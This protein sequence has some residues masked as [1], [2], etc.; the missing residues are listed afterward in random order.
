VQPTC[1]ILCAEPR[2]SQARLTR[3]HHLTARKRPS[4]QGLRQHT[5]LPARLSTTIALRDQGQNRGSSVASL[6]STSPCRVECEFSFTSSR[7]HRPPARQLKRSASPRR[8]YLTEC[9]HQPYRHPALFPGQHATIHSA[10]IL[11]PPSTVR[12]LPS[13]SR[14]PFLSRA[15]CICLQLCTSTTFRPLLVTALNA[16]TLCGACFDNLSANHPR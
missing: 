3:Q 11:S 14:R 10:P 15:S 13:S 4:C 12:F 1:R 2:H 7:H 8:H 6:V 16:R 5:L 9:L